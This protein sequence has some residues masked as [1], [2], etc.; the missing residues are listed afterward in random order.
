MTLL[1]DYEVVTHGVRRILQP[2]AGFI[3]PLKGGRIP[4]AQRMTVAFEIAKRIGNITEYNLD[5]D[6]VGWGALIKIG[7]VE[8]QIPLRIEDTA[9]GFEDRGLRGIA[10]AYQTQQCFFRQRPVQ[11]AYTPKIPD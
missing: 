10:T 2:F 6:S 1:Q 7:V 9:N 11:F 4:A 3:V 8:R 5:R